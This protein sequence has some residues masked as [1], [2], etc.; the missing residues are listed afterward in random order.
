ME[1]SLVDIKV[2]D[3]IMTRFDDEL[4]L[5]VEIE[6]EEVIWTK[7]RFDDDHSHSFVREDIVAVYRKVE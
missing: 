7:S 6:H 1:G 5:V 2:D 3:Y 4:L